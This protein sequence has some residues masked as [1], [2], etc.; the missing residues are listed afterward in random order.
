MTCAEHKSKSYDIKHEGGYEE[1]HQ[2]S[3][4]NANGILGLREARFVGGKPQLHEEYHTGCYHNPDMI[5]VYLY[6]FH[7]I[8]IKFQ[9]VV[10]SSPP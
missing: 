6:A 8:L 3:D 9:S 2:V 1:F 4:R 10:E 7:L 5:D